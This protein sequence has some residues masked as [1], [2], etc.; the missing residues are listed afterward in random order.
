MK[1]SLFNS[2]LSTFCLAALISHTVYAQQVWK[3]NVVVAVEKQTADYY[4]RTRSK[5][6]AQLVKEQL[7][8]VNAKFNSSASFRGTYNFQVDSVYVFAGDPRNEVF[9]PHPHFNY[10]LVIDGKFTEPTVGGGWWGDFQTIYH[11]WNWDYSGGPFGSD[12]TDGLTHEFAHARGA[13]DIY[14]MR[15]EGSKNP[16]NNN[17][18]EPVKSIMNY[19]YGNI[20][21]DEYTTNLLNS[22]GDGPII[23]DKWVTGPF[24]N[25]IALK[26][27]DAQGTPVPN[28]RL[29]LFPVDWFSYS[30]T[31]TSVLSASTSSNGAYLFSSNP[32][33]PST[34]GYPWNIRYSNFLVKATYNSVVAYRWMPLYEVQNAYFKNGTNSGYTT[35]IQLPVTYTPTPTIKLTSVSANR[36]QSGDEVAVAFT[37][38][39]QFESTNQFSLFQVDQND[40]AYQIGR[41]AS[42]GVSTITGKIITTGLK[43]QYRLQIISTKPVVKSDDYPISVNTLAI[44]QPLYNCETGAITFRVEGGD[45]TAI[46]FSAPGITRSQPTAYSGFVEQ[47]LRRDPQVIPITATQS[48]FSVTYNF[49]LKTFCGFTPLPPIL[50]EPALSDMRFQVDQFVSLK[51][52]IS[53]FFDPTPTNNPDHPYYPV[54]N[55]QIDGLPANLSI[56]GGKVSEGSATPSFRLEGYLKTPGTYPVTITGSTAAFPDRPIK[57]SFTIRVVLNSY[58]QLTLQQPRYDCQ[59]GAITF[60]TDGGD[61][62]P[63]TYTAPGI[64]RASL[65]SNTGTVEQ[66]LRSDPKSLTITAMQSGQT[67]S[68]IFDFGAYCAGTQ[69]PPTDGSLKLLAPTYDCTTGAIH[70]N[71]SGGNGTLIEYQAAPGITGWTTNPNQFVDKESRTANDVQPFTLM[72]RQSGVTVTYMWNLRSVCPNPPAVNPLLLLAPSYDCATGAFRFNTSGGNGTLIEYQAAP[73][74]TGWTTNPNQFVDRE[75]RTAA[76]VT[77]FTLM[78]RQSGVLVT[79]M[80]NLKAACGRARQG[81]AEAGTDL[82]LRVLGNPVVDQQL[83]VLIEGVQGQSVQLRLT[84]QQG[85]VLE[86]RVV[87]QAGSADEQIFRLSSWGPETLLLEATSAGKH[88]TVRI[89]RQ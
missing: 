81:I 38:T 46:T 49:N 11:S 26:A 25:T 71:T 57:T 79:Y 56:L 70:F 67:A 34:N 64:T 74:I 13:V 37:T 89:I 29:E 15:V 88:Q 3:F 20:V 66:G 41:A 33:R 84:D 5:P 86:R 83:K 42:S 59:T 43:N 75:S 16:I 1:K 76:D 10:K 78:A 40:N 60:L 12:A 47:E 31:P 44:K 85:R 65:T 45:S 80:W 61:G 55:L 23:G 62:S 18:F 14:G 69:P 82:R 2:R 87:E 28:V 9:R 52:F 39:G 19:P 54:W 73:G 4:E 17:T 63:I 36:F 30:V 68:T 77:P 32:Y 22:T 24:P 21:W 72:A 7:A 58:T 48:G 50:R 6:I 51:V 27:I 53:P 35:E 8:T